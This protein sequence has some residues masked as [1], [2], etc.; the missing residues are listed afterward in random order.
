MFDGFI[1]IQGIFGESTDKKYSGWIEILNYDFDVR[2]KVSST[3]SSVGG[4]STERVDFSVF[5]FAKQ[6]DKASPLLALSCAA[7]TH[8]DTIFVDLCRSGGNKV[9][10]MQ[11]K[12]SNCMISS[13]TT[14]AEG[15][16]PTDDV[17]FLYGKIEWSYSQQKRSSGWTAGNVATG[18]SLENNCKI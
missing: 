1:K 13:F 4:A 16:F 5:S 3:A 10:F 11:Y 17:S 6:V 2:Q 15:G 7:G 8:I 18:W 14:S 12:F 9:R